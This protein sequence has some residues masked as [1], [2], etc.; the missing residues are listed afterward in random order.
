MNA[1]LAFWI[2]AGLIEFTRAAGGEDDICAEID[3]Y[4]VIWLISVFPV[5]RYDSGNSFVPAFAGMIPLLVDGRGVC[6][7]LEF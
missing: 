3:V 6:L 1:E 5:Y 7:S 2:N 4:G